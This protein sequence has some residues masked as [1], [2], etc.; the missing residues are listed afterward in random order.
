MQDDV[1][2]F[3]VDHVQY[4]DKIWQ[5]RCQRR[6]QWKGMMKMQFWTRNAKRHQSHSSTTKTQVLVTKK[7]LFLLLTKT[8]WSL[9]RESM[10]TWNYR[11]ITR[12]IEEPTCVAA[13]RETLFRRTQE[14]ETHFLEAKGICVS[15]KCMK[16]ETRK[17]CTPRLIYSMSD[18]LRVILVSVC[19]LREESL[20]L[21]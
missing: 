19:R 11:M 5:L 1:D 16:D 17:T 2:T 4:L 13:K 9:R 12:R 8:R 3:F 21:K 10:T 6:D 14:K 20:S 15:H 7:G 18:N